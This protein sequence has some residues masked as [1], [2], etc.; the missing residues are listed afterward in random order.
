M[1]R[2]MI[3]RRKIR[4]A[5]LM[6]TV[7]PRCFPALLWT[8]GVKHYLEAPAP[9]DEG[10]LVERL[11]QSTDPVI[12]AAAARLLAERRASQCDLPTTMQQVS[13]ARPR[14]DGVLRNVGVCVQVRNDA[15]I[16]DEYIAFHWLQ[17]K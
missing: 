12:K 7:R 9:S 17:V 2:L 3:K 10:I 5:R 1:A 15:N 13:W 14:N 6:M 11:L 8:M 4:W 16:L